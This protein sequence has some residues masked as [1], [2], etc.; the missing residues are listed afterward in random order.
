M[1]TAEYALIDPFFNFKKIF[2]YLRL[3]D[4]SMVSS[5]ARLCM[6]DGVMTMNQFSA[7]TWFSWDV[8]LAALRM[9]IM[10]GSTSLCN[11]LSKHV[12]LVSG[13]YK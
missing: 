8:C 1:A 5:S 10:K 6:S 3:L 11:Y 4:S 13:N 12:S 9:R 7:R 2:F